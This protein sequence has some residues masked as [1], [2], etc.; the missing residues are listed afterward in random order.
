MEEHPAVRNPRSHSRRGNRPGVVVHILVAV[1][2]SHLDR[3]AGQ[4]GSLGSLVVVVDT[5][6]Y[7]EGEGV[8]IAAAAVG[9]AAAVAVAGPLALE[10]PV[11]RALLRIDLTVSCEPTINKQAHPDMNNPLPLLRPYQV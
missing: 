10:L 5:L 11:L 6:A 2:R 8:R 3:L 4:V 9:V 7:R 1:H